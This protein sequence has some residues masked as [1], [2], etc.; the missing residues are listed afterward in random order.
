MLTA[1]AAANSTPAAPPELKAAF[2]FNF[3][4]FAEWP[5]DATPIVLCVL[6]DEPAEDAL[7]RL[8]TGA[9]IDGRPVIVARDMPR[10]RLRGCQLLYVG[11]DGPVDAVMTEVKGAPVLTVGNGEPFARQ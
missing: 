6:H 10:D 4:K 3:A 5:K 7:A 9:S 8:V 2:L 11:D 1:G